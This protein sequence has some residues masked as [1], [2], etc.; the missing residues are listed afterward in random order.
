MWL[1]DKTCEKE[2]LIVDVNFWKMSFIYILDE[3]SF[4]NKENDAER[5]IGFNDMVLKYVKILIIRNLFVN[6]EGN[7]LKQ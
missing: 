4:A 6:T 7:L 3:K 5:E 1:D 2:M